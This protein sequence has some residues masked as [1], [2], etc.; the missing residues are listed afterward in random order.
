MAKADIF[1][2]L[3]T[4][5][6]KESAF[7]NMTR[8]DELRLKDYPFQASKELIQ[9]LIDIH[10]EL[11]NNLVTLEDE[12]FNS[13]TDP[14]LQIL[15]IQRYGQVF[16]EMHSFLQILEM[17][18]RQYIPQFISNLIGDLLTKFNKKAKFIFLP[19]YDYNYSYLEIFNPLKEALQDALTDID[20]KFDFAEKFA[21]FW[22]PIA[23]KENILL[24]ILLFHEL[25]HFINEEKM[26]VEEIISSVTIPNS[27]IE[28]I[29]QNWLKTNLKAEKKEIKISDYFEL[30]TAKSDTKK[31]VIKKVS[32]R[33]K[34][35]VSDAVAFSL[36]GPAFLIS[37][38]NYLTSLAHIDHRAEGYP[39]TRMRL[40]FLIEQFESMGYLSELQKI[41]AQNDKKNKKIASEFIKIII[42]IKEEVNK[43]IIENSDP[44]EKLVCDAILSVKEKIWEKVNETVGSEKYSAKKFVTDIFKLIDVIDSFTPPVEIEVEHPANPISIL[45]AGML[46][47]A[48][49]MDNWHSALEDTKTED[50]LKT[51]HHLNQII[52][53][54]GE[55]SQ[56]QSLLQKKPKSKIS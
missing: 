47:K 21:I 49:L 54:A 32:D 15:E 6:I 4:D 50:L 2:Q 9:A 42:S 27:E 5:T 12:L 20:K 1:V 41:V 17:G 53:K 7:Y 52:R 46:Y 56:I 30:E 8:L 43:D 23:H 29:A 38:N 34:E 48:I 33:M 44:E 11:I 36:I 13:Y 14:D 16:N 19:D 55:L 40:A 28:E 45:N 26:I 3:L 24:N 25:G 39:S 51:R 35:L 22:F 10:E 37:Q 31:S 18:G